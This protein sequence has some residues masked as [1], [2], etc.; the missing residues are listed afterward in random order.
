MKAPVLIWKNDK[1]RVVLIYNDSGYDPLP[2]I[3]ALSPSPAA[4]G[5][6]RW[7]KVNIPPELTEVFKRLTYALAEHTCG[8]AVL[9][10]T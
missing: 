10:S 9:S 2:V 8:K 4:L 5:E 6:P 1:V 7:E 3:E